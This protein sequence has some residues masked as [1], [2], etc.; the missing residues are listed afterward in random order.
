MISAKSFSL[1][2]AWK[3][4]INGVKSQVKHVNDMVAHSFIHILLLNKHLL[5]SS[6]K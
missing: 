1:V 3:F 5:K 2:N 6:A 4:L